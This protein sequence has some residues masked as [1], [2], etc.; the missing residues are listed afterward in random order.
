M[1]RPRNGR[2]SR[3]G[4]ALTVVVIAVV[5]VV[6][7]TTAGAHGGPVQLEV[8]DVETGPGTVRIEVRLSYTGDGHGV[9]D[10]AVT[11][12]GEV[13]GEPGGAPL[14]P[15]S[16]EPSGDEGVYAGD[17]AVP[18]PGTWSLRVTS[19]QPTA[20]VALDV[21]VPVPATTAP[22]TTAPATTAPATTTPVAQSPVSATSTGETSSSPWW[23]IAGGA[24]A[25]V[26]VGLGI[27]FVRQA[28]RPGSIE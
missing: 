27:V 16:L 13:A 19:A 8:L 1:I 18:V 9:A 2:F 15:V 11:V 24:A 6:G 21:E 14:T 12:A 23:W 22:A 3:L 10:A 25:A 28:S 4:A 17:I 26:A 7:A 20:S 5:A